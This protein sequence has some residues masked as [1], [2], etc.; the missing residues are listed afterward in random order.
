MATKQQIRTT[1]KKLNTLKTWQLIIVLILVLF[2]AAT[3][4]RLNNVGMAQRREGVYSADEAGDEEVIY[5]RLL[6]LREYSSAHMNANTGLFSLPHQYDR[7]NQKAL[8]AAQKRSEQSES[9]NGNIYKKAADVCD[10]QFPG[11]SQAYLQCFMNE[12][13]KYP[14]SGDIDDS[15]ALPPAELYQYNFDSPIWT[16]DLAGWTVLVA[17]IISV[18]IITKII[19]T[20]VLKM[21]LKH[22]SPKL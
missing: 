20:L 4:I 5:Q 16:P 18:V 1:L 17:L 3:A 8:E 2:A 12:L 22:K 21:I 13:D 11:Y 10:P 14:S 9:P 7:D 19:L 15:V 6:T